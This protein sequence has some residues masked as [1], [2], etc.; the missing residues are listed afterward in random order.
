[1]SLAPLIPLKN[2]IAW[3]VTSKPENY[4]NE[5]AKLLGINLLLSGIVGAGLDE[6]DTKTGL[7]KTALERANVASDQVIMLGDRHYDILGA[8]AN[9][10]L[11][12]GAL[13]GYGSRAELSSAGCKHF[14]CTPKE[15]QQ[16]F[17]AN[18]ETAMRDARRSV[19][20]GSTSSTT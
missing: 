15:F 14:A 6:K 16:Q 5:V 20:D 3:I 10:V 12:V 1:M 2:C 9:K 18:T 17:V 4:A 13:W 7:I 11:P 8:L 19:A